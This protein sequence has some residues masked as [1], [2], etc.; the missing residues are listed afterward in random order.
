V[1]KIC[2]DPRNGH[3]GLSGCHPRYGDGAIWKSSGINWLQSWR[4]T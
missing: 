4:A 2:D 3:A 1:E